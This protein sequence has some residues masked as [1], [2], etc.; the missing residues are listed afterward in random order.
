MGRALVRGVASFI[1]Y[2]LLTDS[3]NHIYDTKYHKQVTFN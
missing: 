2:M 3:N 1:D